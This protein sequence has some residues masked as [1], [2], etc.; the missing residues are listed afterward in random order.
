MR[1]KFGVLAIVLGACVL[2]SACDKCGGLQEL[3]YPGG[4]NVCSDDKAR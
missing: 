4:P 3:R 2:L 1:R